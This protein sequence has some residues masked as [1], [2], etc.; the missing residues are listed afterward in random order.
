MVRE[1]ITVNYFLYTKA[2]DLRV[3]ARF[4]RYR[5]LALSFDGARDK[6][7]TWYSTII[8]TCAVELQS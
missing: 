2:S 8:G 5:F 1:L 6:K 4:F 7:C 3:Q